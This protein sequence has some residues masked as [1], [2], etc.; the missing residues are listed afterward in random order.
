MKT[1]KGLTLILALTLIIA[2]LLIARPTF[3]KPDSSFT[4]QPVA[5][6][7]LTNINAS[8]YGLETPPNPS[9]VGKSF[10]VDIHLTGA[11]GVSGVEVHFFFGNILSYAIPTGFTDMLGQSG[12]VLTG[13]V[14]KLLYGVTAGF[15]TDGTGP[16]D[17]PYTGAQYYKVAAAS[18]AAAQEVTDALVVKLTFQITNQPTDLT[19]GTKK[20][21]LV[22]DF[23]D[24]V[25][26]S[27]KGA[28]IQG[29]LTIDAKAFEYPTRANI[30]VTSA[31][32]T[33]ANLGDIFTAKVMITA[34]PIWDVAGFD[35]TVTYDPTLIELVGLNLGGFLQQG[36][37]ATFG[38]NDSSVPGVIHAVFTKL[39]DPSPSS[40]T[41]SL[42][43]MQFKILKISTSFPALSSV[44]GLTNTDLAS[45]AHPELSI[46]PWFNSITAVDLPFDNGP[47][48]P[49]LAWSHTTTNGTYTS[50]LKVAG[51]SVDLYDQY[52]EPYGG[53][54]P[55]AHS[56]AFAPQDEVCLYAKVTFGGDKIVNK[57]VVFEVDNA[58]ST[59]ITLLQNYTD[60]NGVATACFR[61][62]MTDAFGD[63]NI[64]G[65]WKATATVDVDQVV[66]NDTMAF[67][68]GWLVQV[69]SVTAN[70][71]PYLKYSDT[72]NFTASVKT[73]SEQPRNVLVSIDAYDT[74]SYPIG[75]VAQFVTISATR[76]NVNGPGGTTGGI[77]TYTVTMPIP[78]WAR[79]GTE[80]AVGYT[81]TALPANGG[82][83]LGPQSAPALF[84]IKATP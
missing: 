6:A 61:I 18:T 71:T 53:Q 3:A 5:I 72:M 35:I 13:P 64:F 11:S 9:P 65:W 25:A 66:V 70:N 82:V 26:T 63:S 29:T 73:I 84:T 1:V 48:P 4:V 37:A 31:D 69:T 77:Y 22:M 32:E 12:G 74:S 16:L 20:F 28:D 44:L 30:F 50:P 41:D 52:P 55:N 43:E 27:T 67:Q 58:N 54:G 68:V 33:A 75:E 19:G 34:D 23:T 15:Y 79:I 78:D 24:I 10:E 80:H 36:G 83:P 17:A 60:S 14:S 59:K 76:N 38:F 62:P 81:L 56:D 46:G 8:I 7:P 2:P 39:E 40:G 21:P 47:S 51:A 49:A 42:I 57:L 45:W